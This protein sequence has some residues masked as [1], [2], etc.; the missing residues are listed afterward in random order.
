MEN[1]TPSAQLALRRRYKRMMA[2]MV[3][4]TIVAVVASIAFLYVT[5]GELPIHMVIATMVGVG[6]SVLLGS[7][8][9]LLAF[10]SNASGHDAQVNAPD[11]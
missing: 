10:I 9:M 5:V 11:E 8:L 7:G 3:L 4:V 2:W 1:L 6:L